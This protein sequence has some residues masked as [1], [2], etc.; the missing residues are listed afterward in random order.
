MFV[1]GKPC[2]RPPGCA[3]STGP[4]TYAALFL[5]RRTH[6]EFLYEKNHIQLEMADA[7]RKVIMM[8]VIV[9]GIVVI[10]FSLALAYVV[11]CDHL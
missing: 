3:S 5:L 6:I 4:R 10:F 11:A 1:V 9:L 8:D 7:E 2:L